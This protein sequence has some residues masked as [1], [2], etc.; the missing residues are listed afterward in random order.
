MI[1][2]VQPNPLP[3]RFDEAG[4]L[5]SGGANSDMD[6]PMLR[7]RRRGRFNGLP[8]WPKQANR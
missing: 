2:C 3:R 6:G 1:G 7:G 5:L 4:F 8:E